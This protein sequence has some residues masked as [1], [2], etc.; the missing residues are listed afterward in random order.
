MFVVK[1][2]SNQCGSGSLYT[3]YNLYAD[4]L[5]KAKELRVNMCD[6]WLKIICPH[7]DI[8]GI[9]DTYNIKFM[10]NHETFL[11]ILFEVKYGIMCDKLSSME[12]VDKLNGNDIIKRELIITI[13][14]IVD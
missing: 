11:D 2:K 10:G 8:D 9:R 12:K 3:E 1:S 4:T 5:I 14:E 7:I 6:H 13:E